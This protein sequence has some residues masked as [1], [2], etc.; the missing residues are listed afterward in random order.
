IKMNFLVF[1]FRIGR[2]LR[3]YLIFWWVVTATTAACFL[4]TIGLP[5][6]RCIRGGNCICDPVFEFQWVF[7]CVGDVVTDFL[8]LIF[9]FTI[10]WGV[11]LVDLRKKLILGGSFSLT[12]FT[13]AIII[14]IR[15]AHP[16]SRLGV[17]TFQ[18]ENLIWLWFWLT[19]EFV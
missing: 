11:G 4:V 13:M 6:Y 19:V 18:A 14:I 1:F 8:I 16:N 10:L 3:E 15:L 5:N 2:K 17:G 12:L 7:S 9:P